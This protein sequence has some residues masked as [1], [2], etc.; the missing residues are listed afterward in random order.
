MKLTDAPCCLVTGEHGW[1]ANMERIMKAQALRDSSMG[2]YMKS[3]KTMEINPN[4]K[5]LVGI[6]NRISVDENDNTIKDLIHLLF[7]VSLISSGFSLEDPSTFATLIHRM[8]V[9]G[10]NMDDDAPIE[11]A[12]EEVVE[13]AVEEQSQMEE[14][15]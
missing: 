3:S 2:G 13:E 4:H 15:D 7:D 14:V 8:I 6:K 9:L 11:E 10:L 1:S 12:I 5:I